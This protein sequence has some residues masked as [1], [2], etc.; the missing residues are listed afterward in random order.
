LGISR[1]GL[2][3]GRLALALGC[4]A[5]V[6]SCGG[7]GGGGSTFAPTPT[8]S[9]SPTP[10]PTTA[11][12]SL[13]AREDWALAQLNDWYLF[14]TLIDTSVNKASYSDLQSYIDALVAPA[15]AQDKD[16]YFTYVTSIAEEDALINSGQTAGF[17][18]RLGY[19]SADNRVFVI[20]TF[21][22]TPAYAANLARGDELISI[23]SQ[24]VS[25]LMSTGGPQAVINALGADTAGVSRTLTV[26]HLSGVQTNVTLTKATYNMNPVSMQ[27]NHVITYGGTQVG[28]INLRTFISLT[29]EDQL[30][31]RILEF[32]NQGIDKVIVD[33]RYNGGG[34]IEVSQVLGSLLAANQVN[35]PF[36]YMTFRPSQSANDETLNFQAE[37]NAI[38]ATKIA[39]I[40][41]GGTASASELAINAFAPYLGKNVALVGSNTFGKP[42]GQIGIDNTACDDRFRIIA[43]A[44]ENADHYGGYFDGLAVDATNDPNSFLNKAS[45]CRAIDDISHQLG[46]PNESSVAAALNW[47]NGGSCTAI[48]GTGVQTAQALRSKYKPLQPAHPS[49]TQ[50]RLPGLY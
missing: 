29:A 32:K 44:T 31:S 34:L 26:Q 40:G 45:T 10:A 36:A 8:P 16:R 39:F 1:F 21:E 12:C 47:L 48:A 6:A 19:D 37:A 30:R 5:M 25:L 38:S 4:F 41:T 18:F 11:A 33:L 42:V 27:G 13:S 23:G 7:G 14:P 35:N 28:Y 50:E 3:Y 46:D 15:R 24:S 17:G 2:R 43:F 22:G 49:A 9:P 20:E